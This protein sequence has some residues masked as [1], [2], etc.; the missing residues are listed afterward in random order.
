MPIITISR[1]SYSR[2]KEVAEKVAARLGYECISRDVL[3]EA[4]E[5][6]N[7]PEIRLVRAI[8]DAPSV[9]D[10]FRFGKE[11][12]VAF[13]RAALLRRV[14][15]DNI[16][17]HGLAGHFFLQNIPH[18]LKVRIIAD[19]EDRVREEMKREGVAADKAR[20]LIQKDD[21]ERRK[22]S[23]SLYG[24]D[25]A[26]AG[27]YDMVLSIRTLRV[28]DV[29]EAIVDAAGRPCF[30]NTAE[31]QR[32]LDDLTLAAQVEIALVDEFP[33]VK[34]TAADG[35]VHVYITVGLSR[36]TSKSESDV[37]R[38]VEEIAR[39]IGGAQEVRV[40]LSHS[41]MTD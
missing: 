24:I 37:I 15:G 8:H 1:G 10:R 14:Q 28:D 27:L 3:I 31:S 21:G 19:M 20:D 7:I 11:R 25:T 26:D 32:I 23:L 17:Y 40:H 33:R 12:Y 16:V 22:W 6:F 35:V 13:I 29:V 18:V 34:V 4:S 2:G 41:V 38:P 5:I 9:L 30:R 36:L 39:L